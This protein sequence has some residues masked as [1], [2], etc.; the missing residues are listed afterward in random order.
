MGTNVPLLLF[1]RRWR[2]VTIEAFSRRFRDPH[3]ARMFKLIF[4]RHEHF[5]VMGLIFALGW[6]N[7]RAAGHPVGG[8][9]RFMD[10]VLERYATLGGEARY[11]CRVDRIRIEGGRVRGVI[12][13]SGERLD[14]DV[15]ISA[16][17]LGETLGSL[18]GGRH[19]SR[20]LR[21]M[22]AR[23]QLFPPMFQVGLGVART[24]EQEEHKFLLHFPRPLVLGRDSDVRHAIVKLGILDPGLA[25]DGGTAVLAHVRTTDHEHWTR[26]RAAD[27]SR[28]REE[29]KRLADAVI[30]LVDRRFGG[31]RDHLEVVDVAT[32]A[33]YVRYTGVQAGSYQGWAPTPRLI[34]RSLPKT[35][36]GLRGFYMTGQW[37]EPGGGLPKVVLSARNVTQLVCR[38]DGR[39][40]RTTRCPGCAPA[41]RSTR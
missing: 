16:A 41:G 28:Y 22:L 17:D 29:K 4:P 18:L 23:P 40:F 37:V 32:P 36:P 9:A 15:V 21:A 39:R 14:A 35:V 10:L 20:R 11:G 3:L 25:P 8:S 38:D 2:S 24:F 31:V 7:M 19:T 27:R 30:D 1:I 12:L 34:G 13:D 26:L 6:M 5:S 33:T